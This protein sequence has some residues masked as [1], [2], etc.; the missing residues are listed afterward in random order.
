MLISRVNLKIDFTKLAKVAHKR[1]QDKFNALDLSLV[2]KYLIDLEKQIV[3]KIPFMLETKQFR[4]ALQ[5]A[6]NGGDPNNINKVISEI[7][8]VLKKP[9]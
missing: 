6:V 7:L 4:Q 9:D 5:I 2:S 8:L 1:S 3:K